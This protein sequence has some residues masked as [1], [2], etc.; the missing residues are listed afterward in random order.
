M[1]LINSPDF[2]VI[3]DETLSATGPRIAAEQCVQGQGNP[4]Q[5]TLEDRHYL[6]E[7]HRLGLV[8]SIDNPEQLQALHHRLEAPHDDEV[9]R[10]DRNAGPGQGLLVVPR[11][12]SGT[13]LACFLPTA[14]PMSCTTLLNGSKIRKWIVLVARRTVRRH[15]AR[16]S[17][18]ARPS[19][20]VPCWR[21][22]TS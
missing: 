9:R 6:P 22:T 21:T 5:R 16:L 12:P 14:R 15:W 3:K 8:L 19:G 10:H 2:N 17:G 11:R 13:S 7:G 1:T 18:G 4:P 20:T